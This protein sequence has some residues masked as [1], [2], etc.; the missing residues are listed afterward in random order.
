M[1]YVGTVIGVTVGASY[2]S[3]T[4]LF[5]NF[6]F[7]IDKIEYSE[8]SGA[9]FLST[10]LICSMLVLYKKIKED[11]MTFKCIKRKCPRRIK[12]RYFEKDTDAERRY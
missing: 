4:I 7:I 11:L 10:I 9:V 12:T 1:S 2:L 6:A 5:T 3:N 8:G